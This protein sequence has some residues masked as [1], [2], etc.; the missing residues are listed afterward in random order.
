MIVEIKS[1]L[2]RDL[3]KLFKILREK[4]KVIGPRISADGN[5]I[6]YEELNDYEELARD[7][8]DLQEPGNYRLFKGKFFRHGFDSPKKYLFPPTLK[9]IRVYKGLRI[10]PYDYQNME[11]TFFAIKPCD[12]AAIKIMDKTFSWNED[13]YY[14]TI[15]EK[16]TIIVE[17]CIDPGKTCFCATMGT[18]PRVKENFDIAYTKINGKVLFEVGSEK[19][20][21]ILKSLNELREASVDDITSLIKTME[22]AEKK[23]KAPF[24]I[25]N[26]P[27]EL[28]EKIMNKDLWRKVS[29]KCVG[30]GNCTMVCPTCFCFDIYDESHLDEYVDRIRYWDSCF[31]YRYAEVAGGNFRPDLWARYRQWLLHKFSYWEKQ[32]D[33]LGCVGCGRCITWCPMGIDIRESIIRVLGGGEK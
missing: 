24:N 31:T 7:V 30:C 33:T 3:E 26:L 29:E 22:E 27:K 19:G 5:S 28:E 2:E 8:E 10:E 9:I 23:A 11:I 32:F 18:G 1:G 15:R 4:T 16:L 14:K 25:E 17:N 12:S 21:K 20:G 6:V 13:V